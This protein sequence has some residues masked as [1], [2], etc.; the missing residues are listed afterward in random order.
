LEEELFERMLREARLRPLL[1]QFCIGITAE[2]G[3]LA[4]LLMQGWPVEILHEEE[5]GIASALGQLG[6]G[7]LLKSFKTLI[8]S[9]SQNQGERP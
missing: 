9:E 3:A 5:E 6:D 2:R 7:E 1:R 8:M 4:G